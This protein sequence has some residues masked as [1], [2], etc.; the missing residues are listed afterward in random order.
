MH[1]VDTAVDLPYVLSRNT[2]LT[3]CNV[4][5]ILR[6]RTLSRT[7]YLLR[8][9]RR[10]TAS[11]VQHTVNTADLSSVNT[12]DLLLS[13]NAADLLLSVNTADLLLSVNTADLLLSVNAAD[14]LLSVNTADL[15]LSVNTADL[16]L[17][18]QYTRPTPVCQY[19][20]PAAN[21]IPQYNTLS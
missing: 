15:L 14:L 12:A 1:S 6:Y 5:S 20:R 11:A 17:S 18:C 10:G 7:V 21:D 8:T 19:S 4:A 3:S 13:V 2:A 9:D 16:L